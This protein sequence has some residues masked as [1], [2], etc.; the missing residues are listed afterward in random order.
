MQPDETSPSE[1]GGE[2]GLR[3]DPAKRWLSRQHLRILEAAVYGGWQVPE[4]AYA[5]IPVDL[6]S[7][8]GDMQVSTRDRVRAAEALA[9]LGKQRLE[10]AISYDRIMRLEAGEATSRVAV[11]D[12]LSD[13]QIAAVAASLNRPPTAPAPAEAPQEPSPCKQPRRRTRK[14]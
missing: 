14:A 6:L 13:A 10:A 3:G 2:G 8:A 11:V 5:T 12:G 4:E 7:I 1:P 9:A